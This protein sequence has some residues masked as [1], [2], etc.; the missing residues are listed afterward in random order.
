MVSTIA[1]RGESALAHLTHLPTTMV[2]NVK[3][4]AQTLSSPPTRNILIRRLLQRI[5]LHRTLLKERGI[6]LQLC[7]LE[8]HLLLIQLRLPLHHLARFDLLLRLHCP[9]TKPKCMIWSIPLPSRP[10]QRK[11]VSSSTLEPIQI[12]SPSPCL[13]N[14]VLFKHPLRVVAHLW[15]CQF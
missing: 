10:L 5:P 12:R 3:L 11:N 7:Q 14:V 8:K 4:L 6:E 1:L 2:R 13:A 15:S 9:L